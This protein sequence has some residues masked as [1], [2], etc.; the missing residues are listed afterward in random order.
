MNIIN[1]NIKTKVKAP[2]FNFEWINKGRIFKRIGPFKNCSALKKKINC[3]NK[4][5]ILDFE[6]DMPSNNKITYKIV[7]DIE[8]QDNKKR[9]KR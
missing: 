9:I 2:Q 1:Q 7:M 4:Y 6:D 3:I 8:L 5:E